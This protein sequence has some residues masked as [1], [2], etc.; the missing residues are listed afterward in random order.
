MRP[1][2]RVAAAGAAEGA[3]SVLAAV[4]LAWEDSADSVAQAA[5][6]LAVSAGGGGRFFLKNYGGGGSILFEFCGGGGCLKKKKKKNINVISLQYFT[7]NI[8]NSIC[9]SI[10]CSHL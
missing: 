1:M 4:A 2:P 9:H 8:I 3:V 7:T 5:S 6:A 10:T